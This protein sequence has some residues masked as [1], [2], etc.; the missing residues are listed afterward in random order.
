MCTVYQQ[1][2]MYT[3]SPDKA[4]GVGMCLTFIFDNGLYG[5]VH[6]IQDCD[7]WDGRPQTSCYRHFKLHGSIPCHM[8]KSLLVCGIHPF[9]VYRINTHNQ[10]CLKPQ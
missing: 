5:T 3:P 7:E 6:Y 8:Q 9:L 1:R 10:C 4:L 2:A